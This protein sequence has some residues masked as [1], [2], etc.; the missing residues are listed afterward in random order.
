MFLGGGVEIKPKNIPIYA[1]AMYGR[2]SEAI[3][4]IIGAGLGAFQRI[5]F[6]VKVVAGTETDQIGLI[7][8]LAK[9]DLSSI[10]LDETL[11]DIPPKENL[12][13]YIVG[14]KKLGKLSLAL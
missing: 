14:K 9:D 3:Q 11:D 1:S 10:A 5:G 2:L 6:A 13:W 12:V 8:F 7:L 4:P